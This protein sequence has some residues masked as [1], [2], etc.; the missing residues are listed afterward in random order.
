MNTLVYCLV[1]IWYNSAEYFIS[2]KEKEGGVAVATSTDD[3]AADGKIGSAVMLD[4]SQTV[5]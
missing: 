2:C 5:H 1:D 3:N 4:I